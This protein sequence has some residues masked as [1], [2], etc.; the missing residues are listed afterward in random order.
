[1]K[2]V[3]F[4]NF[5]NHHQVYVADEL[6]SLTKG[7]YYFVETLQ[8]PESFKK[9]GYPDF[10]NRP[11][12]VRAW[13]NEEQKTLALNL[14]MESD[15]AI[16]GGPT[17][18]KY[19]I[20]RAKRGGLSFDI[21][22][23]WLKQGWKS[24]FS[25]RLLK[26]QWYY[27]TLL[28]KK[29]VYKLCASAFTSA[30]MRIFFSFRN[31]CYKWGYFTE[32][33][34]D[35]ERKRNTSASGVVHLLWCARYLKWKHPE[36]PILLAEKLKKKGYHFVIDMY[37]SGTELDKTKDL[38]E[39]MGVS[40]VINFCGNVPNNEMLQIMRKH[41]IFLFTSDRNEGWGAVA[42]EAMSNGCVLVGSNAI[43]SV[44]YL[45]KDGINGCVFDSCNLKSLEAKVIDLLDNPIKRKLLSLEGIKTM[46]EVWS[47]QNAAQS[48]LQ[49]VDDLKNGRDTSITDGPCS[50]A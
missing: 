16:F 44:P 35:F 9:T 21:S 46:R 48:F 47:P 4:S 31:K 40:D 18:I 15:V 17:V 45:V 49:L 13:Q 38:S 6:Y 2:I 24:L 14:A 8:M 36:L 5:L 32:V 41:D 27:H 3:F 22:E 26:S 19:E 10:S 25:P 37:G 34:S 42:N 1:M 29:P 12:L 50:K 7:N 33:N 28:Y 11:Y 39:K 30:D 43:G 20:I 23:H